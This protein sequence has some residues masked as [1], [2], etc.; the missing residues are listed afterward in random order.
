MER[1]EE[2]GGEGAGMT[3]KVRERERGMEHGREERQTDDD[4][5][6]R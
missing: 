4:L 5:A 2:K 3:T 6:V 1:P